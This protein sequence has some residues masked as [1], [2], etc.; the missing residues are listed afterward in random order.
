[1]TCT[2]AFKTMYILDYDD[3][4]SARITSWDIETSEV[5]HEIPI[6]KVYDYIFM[7]KLL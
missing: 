3:T 1:M 4:A 5:I 7:N 2:K 6:I